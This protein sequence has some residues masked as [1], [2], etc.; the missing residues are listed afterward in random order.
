MSSNVCYLFADTLGYFWWLKV[1]NVGTWATWR[2]NKWAIRANCCSE[3]TVGYGPPGGRCNLGFCLCGLIEIWENRFKKAVLKLTSSVLLQIALAT[4]QSHWSSLPLS[5]WYGSIQTLH[6]CS[7]HVS[8]PSLNTFWKF[9]VLACS[10][11]QKFLPFFLSIFY[12]L[13][14]ILSHMK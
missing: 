13:M 8:L 4:S 5:H 9:P 11:S 14:N 2:V 3:V 10:I 6:L 12:F 7:F 1:F